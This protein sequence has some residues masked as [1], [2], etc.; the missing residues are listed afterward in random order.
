M[1]INI[2]INNVYYCIPYLPKVL[3]FQTWILLRFLIKA[4]PFLNAS[5]KFLENFIILIEFIYIYIGIGIY[6]MLLHIY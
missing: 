6:S 4:Y 5:K 3:S 2:Y 1:K